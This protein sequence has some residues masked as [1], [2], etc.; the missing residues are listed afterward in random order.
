MGKPKRIFIIDAMAMAFRSFF[1]LGR[2]PL[3]THDGVPISAVYASALFMNKLLLEEKPDYLAIVGESKGA[4]FRTQLYK[5]YKATRDKMPDDLARQLPYFWQLFEA[6][7]Y[8]VLQAEG[9]EADDV[10]G[11]LATRY[12]SPDL[13]VYIVSGDKD[14]MQLISDQVFLYAPKKGE[15]AVIVD[16]AG[17]QQKFLCAPK[18]VIECLA[19]I[20]DTSDN[21]PGVPGIGEKGA[22]KLIEKYQTLEGIYDH[23]EEITAK[24]QRE[25]LEQNKEMA[26]LS[27]TLVT[28]KT[29]LDLPVGLSDFACDPVKTAQNKRV[30]DFY[31]SLNFKQ[32]A[33]KVA[34]AIGADAFDPTRSKPAEQRE[35][36]FTRADNPTALTAK[37][38]RLVDAPRFAFALVCKGDDIIS[39]RPEGIAFALSKEEAFYVPLRERELI[40]LTLEDARLAIKAVLE[41]PLVEKISDTIKNAIHACHAVGIGLCEPYFDT[42]IVDY[43]LDPNYGDH[44]LRSTAERHLGISVPIGSDVWEDRCRQATAIFELH[45]HLAAE[46]TAQDMKTVYST[47]EMPLIAVLARAERNGIFVDT[48]F[49][50]TFSDVLDKKAREF[51]AKVYQE[52]GETFN[53]GSPKQLQEILFQK[54]RV[55]EDLGVRQ[56]KKTKTGFSTD[57]SVLSKLKGHPVAKAILDWRAV[58]KLKSTYVDAL[59]QYVNPKSHRLHTRLNQ[60]VAATGRLSSDK[61]NLQNI[62]MRSELGQEI[63]KA[64][65]PQEPG[66]VLI[67]ADYSQVE[68]RLLASMARVDSLIEA[69][70]LGHDIHRATAAKIFGVELDR[71]DD[72]MRSRAKAINFGII[73]GMGP[74]RLAAETGVTVTEAKEFIRKYFIA[75]PGIKDFTE[76]LVKKA[77]ETGVS[78][79]LCGRKR[80]IPGID[81]RN[82]AV[83]ARAENIAINAPIQ[84]SAADLIKLAMI[85]IDRD[86]TDRRLQA[87]MLLQIHDEL[88]FECPSAEVDEVCQLVKEGMENALESEVP[89][90][91]E[92]G[93][94]HHWLEA[95]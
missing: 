92:V 63:R 26:F 3:T 71:V 37:M 11:T 60:T 84:G 93:V 8:P 40:R 28:L 6:Y 9:M 2:S 29:N 39:D 15:E 54:L 31:R 47:I 72:V 13:H 87:R 57:E 17:V 18:Q 95:H 94:G 24:K 80:P 81:E 7:G 36:H 86:L 88:L 5:D 83:M 53:I 70:R 79:T 19:L 23:L 49:L 41:D 59:P 4:T 67:S 74:Q 52:A 27:R 66:S 1:A 48:E 14:F 43:L 58:T 20:G 75:Y 30:L 82:R 44:S 76:S 21:V 91:V 34:D 85:T 65:R 61:P 22:A 77:R 89:L 51:E 69:F 64:F 25:G 62:P 45:D 32:L 10:I 90:I 68:I 56:L 38:A 16:R 12:A 55:H 46:L 73:Y 35:E 33:A 42:G 78:T 50:N